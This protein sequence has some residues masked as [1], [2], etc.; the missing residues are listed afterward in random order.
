MNRAEYIFK[1]LLAD[2]NGKIPV[3]VKYAAKYAVQV[4]LP[5]GQLLKNGQEF[6]N[7]IFDIDNE[8][9]E[10]GP[11]R[12]LI[13]SI[14]G[15]YTG[16]LVFMTDIYDIESL[17][18][19]KK[20]V[21][22]QGPFSNLPLILEHKYR[23]KQQFKDFTAGLTYDLS[24]YKNLFD[25]LDAQYA[26]EPEMVRQAVQ[27][28]IIATEGTGFLEY[29]EERLNELEHIVA[30]FTKEEHERHG[31]YFR[32]QLWNNLILS[33][34]FRRTNLKPR[35]Y[36]GDSEMMRMI[37]LKEDL[38]HSTFSKLLH[39]HPI[40]CPAA[41]AVRNRRTY[42]AKTVSEKLHRS[43]LPTRVRFRVLS[44]A[45]GPAFELQDLF[46]G[47]KECH[48]C[49][50]TLLDQDEAALEE[51]A[52]LVGQLEQKLGAR[53]E[54]DYFQESV[55]TMLTTRDL[56]SKLGQFHL[57]Y[58]MGL[59]DYLTPPVAKAVLGNLFQLLKPEG[60]MIIGNFHISNPSRIYMEYWA[61]W[62]LYY[63][64]EEDLR[65]LLKKSAKAESTVVFDDTGIQMFLQLRKKK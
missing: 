47:S 10:L 39:K 48:A 43:D 59:F 51:A 33:P 36:S 49:H 3:E 62:V 46:T 11:C 14:K 57:V 37:Y 64:T 17:L 44:V 42:I 29:H 15:D 22:L 25:S 19:Q 4:K 45:C 52:L 34:I 60:E 12:L 55:R 27:Q 50:F 1:A 32:K 2:N 18:F 53:I 63:R 13:E 31:F 41:Q 20:L 7:L 8:Q 58:S 28:T 61:D 16:Y 65:S 24:V 40:E 5:E 56:V 38:G 35:G 26:E 30:D 21:I 9:I 54:V 23:I 6:Q